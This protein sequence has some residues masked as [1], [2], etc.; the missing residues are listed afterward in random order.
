[1]DAKTSI[2]ESIHLI[3]KIAQGDQTALSAFYDKHASLAYRLALYILRSQ[4]DAEEVVQ[5]VFM[6]IWRKAREYSPKKGNP[7]AWIT[8]MTR[9]RAIDKLRIVRRISRGYEA[10]RSE[11]GA[12][13]E[14][15]KSYLPTIVVDSALSKLRMEQR[16]VLEL[17]YF[18][19]MTHEE[20][21][22]ELAIPLG[23][24]KTRLRDGLKALRELMDV[25]G[26]ERL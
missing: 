7:E 20:I 12:G 14:E 23:T 11:E 24:A 15:T 21:A 13:K 26:K 8:V 5:E 2:E 22:K 19:G 6:Q 3:Q 4:A 16:V 10:V 25:K 9:S 18:K 1:M 17:A